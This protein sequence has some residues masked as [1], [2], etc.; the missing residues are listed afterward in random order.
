MNKYDIALDL[1]CGDDE[2]R[3]RECLERAE[4]I[5]RQNEVIVLFTTDIHTATGKLHHVLERKEEIQQD[6]NVLLV[7]SGDINE[8]TKDVTFALNGFYD[9]VI[10]GNHDSLC[11]GQNFFKRVEEAKFEYIGYDL[12]KDDV[13]VFKPY[14]IKD[15]G[16]LRLGIVGQGRLSTSSGKWDG[17][18]TKRDPALL[19][20]YIDE[21]RDEVD[22]IILLIH[23]G[24]DEVKKL[25]KKVNGID[26][27]LGAHTHKKVNTIL[28]DKDGKEVYLAQAGW[29]LNFYGEMTISDSIKVKLKNLN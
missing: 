23:A 9:Y 6:R 26:V 2:D 17:M 24:E 3:K 1:A 10:A 15:Y 21:I 8:K 4:M 22:Y 27:V 28:N 14:V 7:D 13:P 12:M 25:L 29:K 11:N 20:K 19:Q 18:K 16:Y 5:I